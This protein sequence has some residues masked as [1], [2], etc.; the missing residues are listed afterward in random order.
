MRRR[1]L[2][3]GHTAGS[4]RD[5]S[6]FSE[7]SLRISSILGEISAVLG[8]FALSSWQLRVSYSCGGPLMDCWRASLSN[9]RPNGP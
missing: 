5:L 1:N 3:D 8:R 6:G 9:L 7:S 4:W 2:H